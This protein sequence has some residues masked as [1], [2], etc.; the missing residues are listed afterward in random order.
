MTHTARNKRKPRKKTATRIDPFQEILNL[1]FG[2]AVRQPRARIVY[3]H[4]DESR[5]KQLI[6]LC[7]PD[8]H[9][10]SESAKEATI[11]LL[12]IRKNGGIIPHE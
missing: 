2:G 10:G 12:E 8:K 4:I 5:M 3:S 9:N 6:S 7:H 1:I 11:W